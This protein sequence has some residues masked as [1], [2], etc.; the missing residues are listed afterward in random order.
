[1]G[2]LVLLGLQVQLELRGITALQVL[3]G[4]RVQLGLLELRE[5]AEHPVPLGLQV[6]LVILVILVLL[7]LQDQQGQQALPV[8]TVFKVTPQE[9]RALL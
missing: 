8:L 9:F 7:G 1:M 5:L 2:H 4:L 3:L 6:L